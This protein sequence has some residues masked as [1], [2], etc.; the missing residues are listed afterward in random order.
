MSYQALYRTWRPQ[1][2]ASLIGQPHVSQT[3]MNAISAGQIA[4]AYLFS[5]PRGTGKTSMAK[6]F[7][8]AVNCHH[9]NGVE[10]CNECDACVSITM[11]TNVDVEE[12]DAASNR[13]VDEIRELRDKVHYAPTS[14]RRKVYI[15]DEVHM[16][17]TEAFNALLKTLEEPPAHVLF[18]LA[19]TEPHKIPNTIISRCQRFD[20]HRI[21]PET[22]VERLQEVVAH[23][24]WQCDQSALWKVAEAADGGMRDALGLLEQAAAFGRGTIDETQVAAV[25]GGVDTQA[26]LALVADLL[27]QAYLEVIQRL[28]GWYAAGKDANRI[29]FDL[30]QVLRDLFIVRLSTD[31]NPLG[32]KPVAPYRAVTARQNCQPAWLLQAVAKLGEL[33]TQLRYIEQPRLALEAALLS[34][35][36]QPAQ[37]V[38]ASAPAET[39]QSVAPERV[40][41]SVQAPAPSSV[42]PETQQASAAPPPAEVDEKQTQAPSARSQR[43]QTHVAQRKRDM[44]ERLHRDRSESFEGTVKSLW[45]DILQAVKQNRIQTHAWLINGEVV[46][47]TEYAIVLSF[48][49]RIHREAVMKAVDRQVIESAI[50]TALQREMQFFALLK[51]DWDDFLAAEHATQQPSVDDGQ[52]AIVERAKMLFGEEKVIVEDE[53]GSDRL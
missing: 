23:Q 2:F 43:E 42:A 3:L 9:P 34:F 8:K 37:A 18:M 46:L 20:F 11:G 17:T 5:G 51:A 4:H 33:Y 31:E 10:P 48:A 29:A 22:I 38:S 39:A 45:P 32:G 7:A 26:L 50:Q 19:T 47:A 28:A 36:T 44:L 16:L 15:V 52:A 21:P 53:T 41:V 13:G 12:I 30:L 14:V 49:S 35:A 25:I 40:T 1:S 6:L 27:D 24:D